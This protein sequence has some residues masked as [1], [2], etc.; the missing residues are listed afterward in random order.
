M[1]GQD[2][3]A[4]FVHDREGAD[5]PEVLTD[6]VLV[7]GLVLVGVE[8]VV[9]WVELELAA[10][11]ATEGVLVVEERLGA[12]LGALEQTGHRAGEQ[13]DVRQGDLVAG[14]ADVG[15]APV[16]TARARP[17]PLGLAASAGLAGRAARG[18]A[19]ATAARGR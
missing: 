8:L 3:G 16:R 14:D 15:V 12:V 9:A 19:P 17:A 6:G 13:R 5:E 4:A 10:A 2:R 1:G 11:H 18:A 7:L